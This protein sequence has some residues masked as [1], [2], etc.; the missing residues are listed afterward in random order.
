[1]KDKGTFQF[2]RLKLIVPIRK[3]IDWRDLLAEDRKKEIN[4]KKRKDERL[5]DEKTKKK[6]RKEN[7]VNTRHLAKPC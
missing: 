3:S 7:P 5:K 1:L 2:D 6:M 4:N